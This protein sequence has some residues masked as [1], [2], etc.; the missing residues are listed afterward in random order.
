MRVKRMCASKCAEDVPQA[1]APPGET[2]E[3]PPKNRGF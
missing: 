3:K 1:N 2:S